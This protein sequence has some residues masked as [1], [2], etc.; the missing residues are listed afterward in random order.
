M[1]RHHRVRCREER[2]MAEAPRTIAGAGTGVLTE[3]FSSVSV[4]RKDEWPISDAPV[5]GPQVPAGGG[6]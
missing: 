4:R 5:R 2:F 3:E 1:R 6:R